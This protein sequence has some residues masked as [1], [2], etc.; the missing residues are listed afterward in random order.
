MQLNL[1]YSSQTRDIDVKHAG[2]VLENKHYPV[3]I[4]HQI[5]FSSSL[6][7]FYLEFGLYWCTF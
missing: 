1:L 4:Y 5:L 3:K 6:L 2:N 7:F